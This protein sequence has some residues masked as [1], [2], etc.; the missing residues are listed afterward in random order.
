MKITIDD[1]AKTIKVNETVK[2]SDFL[3]FVKMMEINPEEY[4]L[5]GTETIINY[6]PKTPCPLPAWPT[7]PS[8]PDWP[9]NNGIFV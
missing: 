6:W 7:Y 4:S 8:W 3:A 2:L 5:I 9:Y 1:T